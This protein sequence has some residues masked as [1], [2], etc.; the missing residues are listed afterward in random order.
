L[1]LALL[2]VALRLSHLGHSVW[3]DETFSTHLRLG[4]HRQSL[5][6]IAYDNHP[7]LYSVLM[8]LWVS[9]FGDSEVSIRTV[10]L[11]CSVASVYWMGRVAAFL[12]GPRGALMAAA[13]MALSG[14][15]I[16]Y[17]QE[18]RSYS[19]IILLFLLMAEALLRYEENRDQRSLR[20][21]LLFALLCAASHVYAFLFVL[22]LWALLLLSART[23]RALAGMIRAGVT[24]AA[25]VAPLY[26]L[27]A[28]LTLFTNEYEFLWK[29]LTY[30]F[31]GHDAAALLSFYLFGYGGANTLAWV[32]WVAGA[33]F[34]GGVAAA[35]KLQRAK[36]EGSGVPDFSL[37]E[38]GRAFAWS[39][40]LGLAASLAAASAPWWLSPQSLQRFVGPENHPHLMA[41]LPQ[42]LNR[43]SVL[44]LF[45]YGALIAL[46]AAAGAPDRPGPL[47]RMIRLLSPNGTGPRLQAAQVIVALPLLAL[48]LV[49]AISYFRPTY[50]RR[51]MLALLPFALLAVTVALW[52]FPGRRMRAAL[53]AA[54]FA[55][56]LFSLTAQE[57]SFFFFKPDYRR[58]L[59][60]ASGLGMPATGTALW[61]LDN[62]SRYYAGRHE[63]AP[64]RVL[65]RPQAMTVD[66]VVVFVSRAYPLEAPHQAELR[67]LVR[68]RTR[69][70]VHFAGLTLYEVGP[71]TGLEGRR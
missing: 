23:P 66:H 51:Y 7:P 22:C 16:F 49:L 68:T 31:T 18:A 67:D 26:F 69:R 21:F 50:N 55:S 63:I 37:P 11:L 47:A 29:G 4:F 38:H 39:V 30:A 35:F 6:W 62:V 46:W 15:S 59:Q 58:A 19:F 53:I 41:A 57:E 2:S 32:H 5:A 28:L 13:V 12:I 14:A 52:R 43:T 48:I 3:N 61:E 44:Y 8:L 64:V 65:S 34:L 71:E 54:V 9:L 42:L 1:I 45:G 36:P 10:P 56:Q 40:G 70:E 27:V 20:R 33:I 17:A 60:Y 24:Q 25:L